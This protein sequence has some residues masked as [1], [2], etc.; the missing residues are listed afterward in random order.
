MLSILCL[1]TVNGK[2]FTFRNVGILS[3]NEFAIT[4][5][6]AAMSD[7][8]TK[9]GTFYKANLAGISKTEVGKGRS[10]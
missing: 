7:G 2:T 6:Y 5:Q 4:F 1:F 3:D 10:E 9:I 8:L